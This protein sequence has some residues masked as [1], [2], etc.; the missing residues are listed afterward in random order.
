M[1]ILANAKKALRVS[2]R[3]TTVNQKIKS[4]VRSAVKKME[5]VQTPEALKEVYSAVDKA[6]KK[7]IYHKNKGARLKK[8]MAHLLKTVEVDDK[9][10]SKTKKA[11]TAKKIGVKKDTKKSSGTKSSGS[12]KTKQSSQPTA[13]KK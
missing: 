7:N 3:K 8:Q 12:K 2:K 6:V 11:A 9:N 5:Q 13:A 1:P 4:R 10:S